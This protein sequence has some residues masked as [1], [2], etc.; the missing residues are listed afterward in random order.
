MDERRRSY[1]KTTLAA[2]VA[3]VGCAVVAGVA[4][5]GISVDAASM[6]LRAV[7]FGAVV[8]AAVLGLW[9]LLVAAGGFIALRRDTLETKGVPYAPLAPRERPAGLMARGLR[10]WSRAIRRAL[11]SKAG[12]LDLRAGDVVEVRSLAEIRQTLDDRGTLDGVIFMPEMAAACGRR[13]RVFRRVDKLND[14]VG[15]TGLRRL[16]DTVLLEGLRCDGSGH[17]GC[18]AACFIRW[19]E[20]WLRR[21][22][23][24]AA[25]ES[26]T[27]AADPD[28]PCDLL[29]LARVPTE[30]GEERFVCQTTEL[31]AGTTPLRRGDPR[32][33]VRDLVTGNIAPRP[34]LTGVA[35]AAFNGVQ[36]LRRGARYPSKDLP[37]RQTSPHLQLGLVPGEL[38]RVKS[39]SEIEATL[40]SR[41][42]NRGLW[43]DV[44]MVRFCGGEYRVSARVDHVIDERTGHMRTISN[45]CIV[46]EG[47]AATGEYHAFCAQNEVIFWREIWLTRAPSRGPSA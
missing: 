31:A 8:V 26:G 46:L 9:T 41:S 13:F 34:L 33:Y 40:N 5:V 43:F 28:D 39:K 19:K 32:H 36:Q 15:H 24:A 12:R 14:W 38:V 3:A 10:A 45:P 37:D 30:N 47:V 23:G 27:G 7:E 21:V 4:G 2:L 17:G 1:W 16:R 42:R 20:S 11:G 29:R 6:A 25:G 22:E 35:L 18:Q 44:D